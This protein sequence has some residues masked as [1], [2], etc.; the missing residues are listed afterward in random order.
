[1]CSSDLS[2]LAAVSITTF[3][4]NAISRP[5]LRLSE[6]AQVITREEDYSIRVSRESEDELGTLYQS[7]NQML[8]ALK[9]THDEVANQAEQLAKEVAVRKRAQADL[10]VAKEAA[11][12]SNR[13]KSEFLANMSH[14]IRTPLTGILGFT[15][16]LLAGGDEGD[17]A[18]RIEYLSTIQASGKH[19]LTVINDIL[20]LSKIESGRVEFEH[21]GCQPDRLVDEVLRVL[22]VK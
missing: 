9:S 8:D 13:A 19:L 18:R 10:Q 1:M 17:M 22:Q 21:E 4:Q 20:D 3:L 7:F 12:A 6:A 16:V 11:E 5:I 14:E 2:L 15:D